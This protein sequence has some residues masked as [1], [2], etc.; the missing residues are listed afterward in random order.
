MTKSVVLAAA[1]T[2]VATGCAT[3][4][5]TVERETGYAIY[6]VTPEE[7]TTA[8]QIAQAVQAALQKNTSK[9]QVTRGIPPSP[10]PEVSPRFQIVNPFAGSNMA[11]LVARSGADMQIPTC[12]GALVMATA[13]NTGMSEYGEGSSFTVCLWQYQAGYHIDIY[14][15]FKRS[16]GGFSPEMLG[17]MLA[18]KVV[19]DSSQFIPRTVNDIVE[20]VERAGAQV[21][22]VEKYP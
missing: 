10:L 19:G 18:R 8:A 12:E 20:N 17:A 6:Q 13:Q 15:T 7:G 3:T 4:T 16:S 1:L 11:A 21:T 5:P 14:T 2:L 22:L 9:V